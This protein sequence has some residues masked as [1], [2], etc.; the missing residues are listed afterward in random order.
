LILYWIY[1][2][3]AMAETAIL[4][5]LVSSFTGY[6]MKALTFLLLVMVTSGVNFGLRFTVENYLL[7]LVLQIGVICLVLSLARVA[8]LWE[9]IVAVTISM[10]LYQMIEGINVNLFGFLLREN[11]SELLNDPVFSLLVFAPQAMLASLIAWLIGKYEVT[12][13]EE[14]TRGG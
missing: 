9:R 7:C 3:F 14:K 11:P 4:F 12:L 5:Y 6:R 13:F 1:M 2:F 8:A 10:A